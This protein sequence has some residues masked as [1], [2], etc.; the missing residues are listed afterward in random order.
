MHENITIVTYGDYYSDNGAGGKILNKMPRLTSL[1]LPSAPATSFFERNA[2]PLEHL[3]L[4]AGFEHQQFIRNLAEA[5]CFPALKHFEWTDGP[6]IPRFTSC[7]PSKFV[8]KLK[9]APQH[10]FETLHINKYFSSWKNS[11]RFYKG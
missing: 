11:P 8:E 9:Q 2:H 10:H 4:Q 5:K 3:S 6:G 1:T 7:V